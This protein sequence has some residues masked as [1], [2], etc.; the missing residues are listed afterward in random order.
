MAKASITPLEE[1]I[2]LAFEAAK[3]AVERAPDDALANGIYGW[4][5]ATY[6]QDPNG[7]RLLQ[8]AL[9]KDP[10]NPY[11]LRWVANALAYTLG[12]MDEA[13]LVAEFVY[14]RDPLGN[15]DLG[16]LVIMYNNAGRYEDA[17]TLARRGLELSPGNDTLMMSLA[18]ASVQ[19]GDAETALAAVS[20]LPYPAE[21]NWIEAMAFHDLGRQADASDALTRLESL[22]DEGRASPQY[23][24]LVFAHAGDAANAFKWFRVAFDAGTSPGEFDRNNPWV[25]NIADDPGWDA[26]LESLAI[27]QEEL[28][29][30]EFLDK[31]EFEVSL[32]Q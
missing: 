17:I 23:A 2:P 5:L 22:V 24:G 8:R 7:F 16:N 31:I 32:P 20:E 3:D 9:E 28:D 4:L 18:I 21:K 19:T 10:S 26:F 14:E 11:V 25:A 6:E 1:G 13:I 12:R 29:A 15:F 30:I 27:T